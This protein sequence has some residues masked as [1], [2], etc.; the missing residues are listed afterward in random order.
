MEVQKQGKEVD[1]RRCGGGGRRRGIRGGRLVDRREREERSAPGLPGEAHQVTSGDAW[2]GEPALSPDGSR[3][4]YT[5]DESGNKDIYVIDRERRETLRLTDDPAPDYSPAW[6]PD[7]DA[8]AFVSERGGSTGDLEDEL[9]RRG[10][11]AAHQ[12]RHRSGDLARRHAHRVHGAPA[13]RRPAD[14]RGSPRRPA[15]ISPS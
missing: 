1:I 15:Q 14:R 2:Q 5:S 10:R 7:G 6:F 8:L 3:I 13:E 12:G 11:H 4:A 9:A